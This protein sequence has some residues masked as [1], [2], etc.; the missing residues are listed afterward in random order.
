MADDGASGRF[1]KQNERGG[2]TSAEGK[3]AERA[4]RMLVRKTWSS[5]GKN[6]RCARIISATVH[7]LYCVRRKMEKV[8]SRGKKMRFEG[9][10]FT[11]SPWKNLGET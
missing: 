5:A 10:R 3:G 8:V 4:R 6:G 9:P 11:F 7:R 1:D 2:E